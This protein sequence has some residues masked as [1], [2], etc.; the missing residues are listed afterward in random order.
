M[1]KF[2]SFSNASCRQ[3]AARYYEQSRSYAELARCYLMLDDFSRMEALS[4]E[5]HEGHEVL[6]QLAETFASYGL[7]EQAVGCYLKVKLNL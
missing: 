5:L 3:S 7:C 2:T 4:Q 6:N 1:V